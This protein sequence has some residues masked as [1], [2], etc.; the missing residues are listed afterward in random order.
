MTVSGAAH[1][2][3]AIAGLGGYGGCAA[4]ALGAAVI[5]SN[6]LKELPDRSDTATARLRPDR[7]A[8][9]NGDQFQTRHHQQNLMPL[10]EP[11]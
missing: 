10:P 6:Q 5:A 3:D 9:A 8:V 11:Q 4:S 2:T 1:S 7:I